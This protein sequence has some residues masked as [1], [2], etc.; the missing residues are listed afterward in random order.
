MIGQHDA[1]NTI[2]YILS[3]VK[4]KNKKGENVWQESSMEKRPIL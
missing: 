2:S 4:T 1:E 3:Y